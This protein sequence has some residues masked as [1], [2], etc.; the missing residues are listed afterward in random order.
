VTLCS[1]N[2]C[3]TQPTLLLPL[4]PKGACVLSDA[5][6]SLQELCCAS[7]AGKYEGDR[8]GLLMHTPATLARLVMG[9]ASRVKL[10]LGDKATAAAA[11]ANAVSGSSSSSE[12]SLLRQ[13]PEQ[14]QLQHPFQV[15]WR[16]AW[17]GLL[18]ASPAAATN[19]SSSGA[20]HRAAQQQQQEAAKQP[21]VY[22]SS[23]RPSG[24]D[25]TPTPVLRIILMTT[26]VLARLQQGDRKLQ[27]VQQAMSIPAAAAAMTA[28][29]VFS[30]VDDALKGVKSVSR[31]FW[32]GIAVVDS[33]AVTVDAQEPD[34]RPM[35]V[36]AAAFAAQC[37][38]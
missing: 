25:E 12:S 5:L 27:M 3:L 26:E 34:R 18:H 6:R 2:E 24:F 16:A 38:F 23:M 13:L 15:A 32:S 31:E 28:I 17:Q 37:A 19:I 10:Q 29:R 30:K 20:G 14:W 21:L 1:E 36:R 8:S 9:L 33:V 11:A 35:Q 7:V 4:Q 22:S